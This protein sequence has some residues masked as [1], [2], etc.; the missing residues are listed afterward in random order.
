MYIK[1]GDNVVVVSGKDRGK[2]GKVIS[3]FPSKGMVIVEGINMRKK[4]ER[5]RKEGSKGQIIEKA[6]PL[7]VSNVMLVDPKGGKPTRIR[8]K[9][10]NNKKVRV[11]VKSGA[12]IG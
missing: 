3:A 10:V 6:M 2:K 11:A 1:K 4:H 5:P 7:D 9:T 8:M 12:T